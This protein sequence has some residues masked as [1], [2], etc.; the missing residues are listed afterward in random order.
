MRVFA[1]IA[2]ITLSKKKHIGFFGVY[3]DKISA[4]RVAGGVAE[5]MY[6]DVVGHN[7]WEDRKEVKPA[8]IEIE[9]DKFSK[10]W[11]HLSD[12]GVDEFWEG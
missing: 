12:I 7:V 3:S 2:G 1:V 5:S 6:G 4:D 9:L 11:L 8:I 10:H